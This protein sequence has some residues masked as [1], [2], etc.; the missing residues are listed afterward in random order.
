MAGGV[1]R[2]RAFLRGDRARFSEQRTAYDTDLQR[3]RAEHLE[4]YARLVGEAGT[5]ARFPRLTR[6]VLI[7]GAILARRTAVDDL[8]THAA[9]LT[10]AALLSIPALM[11]FSVSVAGFILKGNAAAQQAVLSGIVGILPGDFATSTQM[12]LS[13]QLDA[14]IS[15]RLSFGVLGLAA[16][17]WTASGLASRMRRAMGQIFGTARPGLVVG[18]F[19]GMVVG[20]LMV[21][22]LLGFAAASIV[23][24]WFSSSSS[25][26]LTRIGAFL[27]V[28]VGEFVFFLFLYRV[29]T[30]KGPTLR[31]HVQ[32]TVVF[33][34]GLEGLAALGGFYFSHVVAN[35]TALYGAVGS[36][37]GVIAFL[38]ATSWLLLASAELSAFLWDRAL[39]RARGESTPG[40]ASAPSLPG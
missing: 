33:V 19:H 38:Y 3:L 15:G 10:Y 25:D 30:P 17:L 23:Q 12:F 37:F 5:D 27:G 31:H 34:I 9:A 40:E 21:L 7:P 24:G 35:A 28:L 2:V 11:L 22:A 26:P 14:A 4:R 32:G 39:S 6:N 20:I 18:R 13:R 29:L 8:S 1:G 16:L 36:L